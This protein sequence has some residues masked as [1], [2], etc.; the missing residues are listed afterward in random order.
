[1]YI[2][3]HDDDERRLISGMWSRNVDEMAAGAN[4]RHNELKI[5]IFRYEQL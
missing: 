5:R 2:V 4:S 1:M 3:M